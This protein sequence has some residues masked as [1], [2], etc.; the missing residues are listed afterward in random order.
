MRPS[1]QPPMSKV[2]RVWRLHRHL[3]ALLIVATLLTFALVGGA[4][5]AYR[6]PQVERETERMLDDEVREMSGRMEL[7]MGARQDRMHLLAALLAN[8]PAGERDAMLDS[9]DHSVRQFSAVYR[10]SPQGRVEAAG[11]APALRGRRPDVL[12]R[13]LST[14]PVFLAVAQGAETV[15]TARYTSV[16]TGERCVALA[17][18]EPGGGVL[19]TEL[20]FD[21]LGKLAEVAAGDRSA[22]IWIA[23]RGGAIIAD[24][25]HRR[26]SGKLG[27]RLSRWPSAQADLTEGAT[28]QTFH[29]EGR[30][31]HVA[32]AHAPQLDWYF[33]GMAPMGLDNPAV[34]SEMSHAG[35][36][37]VGCLLTGLLIAPFWA[38]RIA[39]LLQDIVARAAHTNAG[40]ARHLPWPRGPV[41]EFNRLSDDLAAMERALWERREASKAIFNAAPVP[42]LVATA[43]GEYRVLDVNE[44]WCREYMRPYESVVGRRL[45]DLHLFWSR[46]DEDDFVAEA[47]DSQAF[48]EAR[49]RRG[50]GQ[51]MLL[52]VFGGMPVALKTGP[53]RIWATVDIAS[54]RRIERELREL[55]QQLESRVEQRTHALAASNDA[56]LQTLEQLQ[57]AQDQLVLTEKMASLGGLVAGV[58]HEL[59]TPLGNGVMAVSAMA[60]AAR[61]FNASMQAGL[62][63]ADLQRFV[64]S[65][66]HGTDIAERNLR[67]A[68]DLVQSFKQVAVDQRSAQRRSFELAEV[69]H[70]M[71]VSLKP[72]F[73]GQPWRMDVDVPASGLRLDSYPGALGQA[74]GNLIQNAV[75]HGFEGRTQGTV[76]IT[77]GREEPHGEDQRIWLR[78]TDDGVGIAA[79]HIDRI[80]SPFM[81]TKR[82]RGG[83]G[84]G[85]HISHNAVVDLLGGTLTVQSQEGAG[86]CFEVRLPVQAPRG[87]AEQNARGGAADQEPGT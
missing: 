37:L 79:E 20:A 40:V 5:M 77:A 83:T 45:R 84:L 52:R 70:E 80:F 25:D 46:K 74:L 57:V 87:A 63:R 27:I 59:N 38:S 4:M 48:T 33:V 12:G 60:D 76:Q 41:L 54:V 75:V 39:R 23:E 24:T 47:R 7:L 1:G 6:I 66:T 67:R 53:L 49:L 86:S 42:M 13:D 8:T 50:D 36:A 34:R 21:A 35:L 82:G 68:A 16:V 61:G 43:S 22:S 81:T 30:R 85:L 65:V 10:V 56:L 71:V 14:S 72:S 11:L 29:H 9:S 19:I 28:A 64:D 55:N 58:A 3:S 78:V 26:A 69:V 73:A 18:K 17:I 2:L 62:R 15:W 32:V 31:Y 51:G 44:A